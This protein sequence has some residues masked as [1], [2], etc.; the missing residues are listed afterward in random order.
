MVHLIIWRK[1]RQQL[2]H[3]K[4]TLLRC[5]YPTRAREKALI[6]TLIPSVPDTT[7]RF[8]IHNN[9]STIAHLFVAEI[10]LF[11]IFPPGEA[12]ISCMHAWKLTPRRGSDMATFLRKAVLE[13]VAIPG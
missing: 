4:K 3:F 10:S 11:V 7:T 13:D 12:R 1:Q 6:N 9:Y 8:L 5:C 2:T